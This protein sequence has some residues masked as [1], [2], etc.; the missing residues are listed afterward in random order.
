MPALPVKVYNLFCSGF[1]SCTLP[2]WADILPVTMDPPPK[3]S[4]PHVCLLNLHM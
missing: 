4:T 2:T 1:P 3:L